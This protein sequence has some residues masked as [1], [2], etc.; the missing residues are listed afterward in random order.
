MGGTQKGLLLMDANVV[1]D[2]C[3]ADPTV[4][5]LVSE[6]IGRVHIPLPVLL[7][8]VEQVRKEDWT[9]LGIVAVDPP[10]KT[11]LVAAARRAGLSF[12]DRLCLLL[13]RD[14]G[15]TCVTNDIRLRRECQSDGVPVLWGL[16]LLA[17][18]VERDVLT[19]TAAAQLGRA[20]HRTNPRFITAQVLERFLGRI[21]AK[22]ARKKAR[23]PK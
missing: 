1:I 14:N 16:E 18:L 7:E 17:M 6:H 2:L 3:E 21:G 23:K 19:A 9:S 8:E 20:I 15:W 4:I 22:R 11:A 5:A 13:A 10:L 12:H